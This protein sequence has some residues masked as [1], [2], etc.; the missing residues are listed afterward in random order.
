MKFKAWLQS[1]EALLREAGVGTAR[2]D[3]LVLAEHV[4]NVDRAKLLAEPDF[5]IVAA[6]IRRLTNLLKRRVRHEPLAYI[7]GQV[8]FYSRTFVVN[9]H[10]LVPRPESETMID[11]LKNLANLGTHPIIADIG[12]GSGA[13][14]IT[15]KLELPE[16]TVELID[17]DAKALKVAQSNVDIFTPGV[18]VLRSDLLASTKQDYDVLL[19]N[20]PYVPDDFHINTAATH[21]PSLAIYGGA[22]G[23]DCYRKLLNQISTG[24][25]QPL[26]LLFESLPTQHT[27]L[28]SL[29]GLAGYESVTKHDFI[30]VLKRTQK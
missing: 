26:Y 28:V 15:A 17:I 10:V 22:D 7:L 19:C 24:K 12:T 3:S 29:A 8:E 16:A 2:L 13:L 21:E 14:G 5:K 18:N 25:H 11:E 6:K 20:L 1:A 9:E 4:L 30:L 23:L 27:S